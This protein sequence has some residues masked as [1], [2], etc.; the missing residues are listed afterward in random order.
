[1]ACQHHLLPLHRE[2]HGHVKG[3]HTSGSS[4]AGSRPVGNTTCSCSSGWTAR[5][6][7]TKRLRYDKVAGKQRPSQAIKILREKKTKPSMV[8]ETYWSPRPQATSTPK[9]H[10]Q[11]MQCHQSRRTQDT[12]RAGHL[13]SLVLCPLSCVH[14]CTC[15]GAHERAGVS[16]NE[17]LRE[18]LHKHLKSDLFKN[19]HCSHPP[20]YQVFRGGLGTAGLVLGL[21]GLEG[22]FQTEWFYD[23]NPA[24]CIC[25]KK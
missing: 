23:Y 4:G 22:L 21:D 6:A 14:M 16:V 24:G 18:T 15:L 7:G 12:A 13:V 19:K 9:G 10:I 5:R 1:M 20:A 17:T 2:Q 25:S 8:W 11:Q 3:K